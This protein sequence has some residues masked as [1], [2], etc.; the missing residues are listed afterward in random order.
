M[1]EAFSCY[2]TYGTNNVFG[3]YYLRDILAF[4][5]E[6]KVQRGLAYAVVDEV[7]SILVDEARTPL[8]IS[9]PAEEST[10]L[11][12]RINKLVPR[13]KPQLE[14]DGPGD[15]SVEEKSNQVHITTDD[16]KHVD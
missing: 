15:F 16:H 6:D 5:L 3:F 12:L 7:D 13:L 14:E 1:R 4:R 10:E 2:C 8:I 9:G 11:Y